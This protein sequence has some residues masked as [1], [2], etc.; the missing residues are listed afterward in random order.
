MSS[1][2]VLGAPSKQIFEQM[3]PVSG[4]WEFLA[5]ALQG[6][7]LAGCSR[8]WQDSGERRQA[9]GEGRRRRCA[10][11]ARSEVLAAAALGLGP[12][13]HRCEQGWGWEEQ[14]SPQSGCGFSIGRD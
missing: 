14:S 9:T 10:C 5:E 1:F 13:S 8:Q 7:G 6:I 11:S 4:V 3:Q 2:S 12:Q